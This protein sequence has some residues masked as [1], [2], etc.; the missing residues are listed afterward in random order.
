M[1]NDLFNWLAEEGKTYMNNPTIYFPG[2]KGYSINFENTD[3]D[4][5]PETSY[6][7]ILLTNVFGNLIQNLLSVYSDIIQSATGFSFNFMGS[8]LKDNP[9]NPKNSGNNYKLE[10]EIADNIHME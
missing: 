10:Q 3:L 7:G 1:H 2:L 4:H 5:T 8:Q 9:F 6:I